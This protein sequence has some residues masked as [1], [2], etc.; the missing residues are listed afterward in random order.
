MK[1]KYLIAL[2]L[3]GLSFNNYSLANEFG[4]ADFPAEINSLEASS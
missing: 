3:L 2:F 4:N 1:K